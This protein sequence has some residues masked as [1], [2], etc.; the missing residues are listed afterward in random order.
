MVDNVCALQ[1]SNRPH[2]EPAK[3]RLHSCKISVCK[4]VHIP[5][6]W[7]TLPNHPTP[8]TCDHRWIFWAHVLKIKPFKS[9]PNIHKWSCATLLYDQ[10]MIFLRN[11]S[12]QLHYAP[13][14]DI[15]DKHLVTQWK[16]YILHVDNNN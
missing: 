2:I 5:C 10:M 8:T 9:G 3:R 6:W 13:K 11:N 12:H 15:V 16:N 1:S 4:H 7:T 14:F